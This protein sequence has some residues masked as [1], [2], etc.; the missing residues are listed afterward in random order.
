MRAK[1]LAPPPSTKQNKPQI[2]QERERVAFR[3]FT[4]APRTVVGRHPVVVFALSTFFFLLFAKQHKHNHLVV[5]RLQSMRALTFTLAAGLLALAAAGGRSRSEFRS[6][7]FVP[8]A[9]RVQYHGV[10]R[11]RRGARR[12]DGKEKRAPPSQHP[13]TLTH[14]PPTSHTQQLRTQWVDLTGRHCPRFGDDATLA[15]PLPP[16]TL[17]DGASLRGTYKVQLAFDGERLRTPWLTVGGGGAG[18]GGVPVVAVTLTR[19]GR[20]LVSARA[21]VADAPPEYVAAHPAVGGEWA[22]GAP[23][24]RHA[25]LVIGWASLP[26]A[27]LVAG[28]YAVLAA[29]LVAALAGALSGLAGVEDAVA[30]LVAGVAAAVDG[31][32]GVAIALPSL[33]A[34][35]TGALPPHATR[36]VTPV[37]S[38]AAARTAALYGGGGGAPCVWRRV[39]R[40]CPLRRAGAVRGRATTTSAPG[41]DGAAA[42][43][44]GQVG[45]TF[46]FLCELFRKK[47]EARNATPL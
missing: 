14:N 5:T 26:G 11:G 12:V 34:P 30:D 8:T 25:P 15:L 22:P 46:V 40:A 41:G 2:K 45:L 6:G 27:D 36:P 47:E 20:R 38:T 28:A 43:W 33:A 24:P 44:S 37:A 31:G 3:A 10:R 13:L 21:A 32:R 23:W 17:P 18:V 29:C 16:P 7:E 19:A 9:R 42:V 39:W 35:V 4:F 1:R